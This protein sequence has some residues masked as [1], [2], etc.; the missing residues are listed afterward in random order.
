V[1]TPKKRNGISI[2]LSDEDVARYSTF[3]KA[4]NV[5]LAVLVRKLL[6]AAI[7]HFDKTDAWPR[8]IEV[9]KKSKPAVETPPAVAPQPVQPPVKPRVQVPS[10][11]VSMHRR[12]RRS[13]G[14]ARAFA[15]VETATKRQPKR[16]P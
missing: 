6:D 3:A 7:E 15:D 11:P 10:M 12:E 2:R 5:P 4:S 8:E 16:F 1:G 9:V 13:F 14:D